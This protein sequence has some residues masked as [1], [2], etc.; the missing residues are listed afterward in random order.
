V[1]LASLDD[2]ADEGGTEYWILA[3]HVLFNKYDERS[4]SRSG[5]YLVSEECAT[6]ERQSQEDSQCFTGV[7]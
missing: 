5:V 7:F 2:W 6:R 4:E 3:A 1:F